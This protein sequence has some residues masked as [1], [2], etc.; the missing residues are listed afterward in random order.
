[1]RSMLHE[2]ATTPAEMGELAEASTLRHL[3]DMLRILPLL[4]TALFSDLDLGRKL[5][6]ENLEPLIRRTA[7]QLDHY[8]RLAVRGRPRQSAAV[9]R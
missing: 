6:R 3:E 4:T 5:F 9:A 1:M 2:T 8:R 7:L